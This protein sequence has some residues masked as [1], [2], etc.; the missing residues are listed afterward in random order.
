MANGSTSSRNR[1]QQM[2]DKVFKRDDS[3][4]PKFKVKKRLGGSVRKTVVG[5]RVKW[6]DKLGEQRI[7]TKYRRSGVKKKEVAKKVTAKYGEKDFGVNSKLGVVGFKTDVRKYDKQGKEKS[8][9]H[10][11][12]GVSLSGYTPNPKGES[13][14]NQKYRTSPKLLAQEAG[15]GIAKAVGHAAISAGLL[16]GGVKGVDYI[17]SKHEGKFEKKKKRWAYE[18]QERR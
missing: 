2:T 16:I 7:V 9:R 11:K 1:M 5:D 3:N 15:I 18:A 13:G 12:G 4:K 8:L 17:D 6:D 10:K 14:K